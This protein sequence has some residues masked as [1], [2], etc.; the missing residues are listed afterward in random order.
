MLS[1]DLLDLLAI[2]E[3]TKITVGRIAKTKRSWP[4][5]LAAVSEFNKGDVTS[6]PEAYARWLRLGEDTGI[7]LVIPG[8]G[9]SRNLRRNSPTGFSYYVR[10]QI[11]ED[12]KNYGNRSDS[13]IL[14]S[15]YFTWT[16]RHDLKPDKQT[17]AN[18]KTFLSYI[19]AVK[20]ITNLTDDHQWMKAAELWVSVYSE[21][22][23]NAPDIWPPAVYAR[24]AKNGR[25][26]AVVVSEWLLEG[27]P[28]V[29]SPPSAKKPIG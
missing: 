15:F 16:W 6:N 13:D 7:R 29:I 23:P 14:S 21:G 1:A 20:A 9:G 11:E 5:K 18:Q 25:S 8:K 10:M 4:F 22:E 2:G 3:N 28:K 24:A 17:K 26:A 19:T 12:L 27:L